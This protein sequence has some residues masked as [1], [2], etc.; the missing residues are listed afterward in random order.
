[1]NDA[2]LNNIICWNIRR[3]DAE[4]RQGNWDAAEHFEANA[5]SLRSQLCKG[6]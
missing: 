2:I 3:R 5:R 6:A 1:M 4:R